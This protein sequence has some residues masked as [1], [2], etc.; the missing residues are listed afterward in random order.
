MLHHDFTKRLLLRRFVEKRNHVKT[1]L[2]SVNIYFSDP[3]STFAKNELAECVKNLNIVIALWQ[4]NVEL[5]VC[6]VWG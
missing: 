3:L 6:W 5:F 1:V 2:P 4:S